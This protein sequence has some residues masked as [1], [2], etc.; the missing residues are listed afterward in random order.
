MIE[1]VGGPIAK[2]RELEF[3][4]ETGLRVHVRLEGGTNVNWSAK[5]VESAMV[6]HC[7][8]YPISRTAQ[9]RKNTPYWVMALY[10]VLAVVGAYTILY[11]GVGL[12]PE[13][14]WD[15]STKLVFLVIM[16]LT[17]LPLSV[18]LM[19]L[20]EYKQRRFHRMS[21]KVSKQFR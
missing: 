12:P 7:N 8:L 2:A 5:V 19:L 9:F 6:N 1:N 18:G 10:G 16:P 20:F 3:G 4:N 14:M 13:G 21:E 11:L 15:T 17:F